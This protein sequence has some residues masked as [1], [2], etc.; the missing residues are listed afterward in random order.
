MSSV[1]CPVV[2]LLRWWGWDALSW[3]LLGGIT[4]GQWAADTLGQVI[5]RAEDLACC[6]G[7]LED[8]MRA[9]LLWAADCQWDQATWLLSSEAYYEFDAGRATVIMWGVVGNLIN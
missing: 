6:L 5:H 1:P 3:L 9:N 8:M 4:T 2:F 7:L